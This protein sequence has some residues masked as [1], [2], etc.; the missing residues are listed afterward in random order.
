M[1][2]L[3]SEEARLLPSIDISAADRP[4]ILHPIDAVRQNSQP[5]ADSSR[6]FGSR[7][8]YSQD[9]GSAPRN[10]LTFLRPASTQ[11]GVVICLENPRVR[12]SIPRLPPITC[13][14]LGLGLVSAS[15]A[16]GNMIR[17]LRSTLQ[18]SSSISSSFSGLTTEL[19][20][21]NL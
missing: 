9:A 13:K 2:A 5:G 14:K 8:G 7:F 1:W 18:T 3:R 17:F 11:A 4:A 15:F 21:H 19:L 20:R 16:L 6:K 12:G 10:F